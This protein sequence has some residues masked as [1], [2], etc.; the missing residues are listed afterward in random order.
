MQRC[1]RLIN[2]G[3]FWIGEQILALSEAADSTLSPEARPRFLL[4]LVLHR[5]VRIIEELMRFS[6]A[7]LRM[8]NLLRFLKPFTTLVSLMYSASSE[9]LES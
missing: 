3:S 9:Y 2:Y 1:A 4:M 6:E 5:P 8:N 7:K